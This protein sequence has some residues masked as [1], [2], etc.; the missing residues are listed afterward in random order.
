MAAYAEKSPHDELANSLTH[1]LGLLLSLVGGP[2]LI[3]T[4]A[5]T[6]DPWRVVAACIYAATLVILYAA[7]TIYHS[8]RTDRLKEICQRI[9]HS[10]IYLLIAGTYTPFTL[11]S[12]RGA[13]GWSIFGTVWGLAIIGVILKGSY[14]A[15]L[16]TLS[17]W[18]YL[19]MGWAIVVALRPLSSHVDPVGLRWIAL[20]GAF[21][22]GGIVFYVW[23]RV[24]F[25]HAIWHLF[26]LG[27]SAAH[28]AAVL[29]YALPPSPTG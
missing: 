23:E 29:W 6:N 24:K 17:T 22:T 27:G 15:R 9:D 25:S 2:V 4:A 8:V 18:I 20:G 28:F 14:G 26:V 12:L 1:G 11:I 7:S 3:V 19:A 5:A 21:Y 13:W 16:P 10:A